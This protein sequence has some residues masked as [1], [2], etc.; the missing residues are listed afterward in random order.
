MMRN[1][2]HLKND[3]PPYNGEDE[4]PSESYKNLALSCVLY[5]LIALGAG[6]TLILF[7][8]YYSG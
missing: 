2:N 1:F 4:Y 3:Y 7:I 8:L 5:P 6:L